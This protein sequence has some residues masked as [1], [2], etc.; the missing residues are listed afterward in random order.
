MSN[1]SDNKNLPQVRP[2]TDIALV[3]K[4]LAT[5]NKALTTI[6][7]EKFIKFLERNKDAARFF[8]DHISLYSNV[9]DMGFIEQYCDQLDWEKLSNNNS[10]SWS[11]EL[12]ERYADKWNWGALGLSVNKSLPWSETLIES[13]KEK[14]DWGVLGLSV[15]KSLPWSELLIKRFKH[16]WDWKTLSGNNSLPWSESLIERFAD[17]WE[18]GGRFGLSHNKSLPWSES[19]IERFADKWE[20]GGNFRSGLPRGHLGRLYLEYRLGL[21]G[22]KFLPWSVSLIERYKDKLDWGRFG[23]SGN[24]SLPWSESLIERYKDKW[25]WDGLSFNESLP[26][27]ES[28]IERYKGVANVAEEKTTHGVTLLDR[29]HRF[30]AIFSGYYGISPTDHNTKPNKIFGYDNLDHRLID[31]VFTEFEKD[32]GID[33]SKDDMALERLKEGLQKAINDISTKSETNINLPFFFCPGDSEPKHLNMK[34]SRSKFESMDKW[35]WKGLS[36][37]KS[38]PWSEALIER[39]ADQWDWEML[40]KNNSLPWSEELIER[41]KDKWKWGMHGLSSNNS[42]PWSESFI[43]RYK[44]KWHWRNYGLSSNQSLPWSESFIERYA[45]KWDWGRLGLSSNKSL[46]WNEAFIQGFAN[47]WGWTLLASNKGVRKVFNS[48]TKQEISTA[49]ERIRLARNRNDD[50]LDNNNACEFP[51]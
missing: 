48:W 24:K 15:N 38:L 9:L 32:H 20:W 23:L 36:C 8:I 25:S 41:Y 27:S 45:D 47:K 10:L 40:S 2:N 49:L 29:N 16:R 3:S 31:W 46:P 44:D 33:F 39:Y 1:D 43:E 34:L 12:I 7:R 18:W 22:N 50:D 35:N 13:Y 17:K 11:E 4:Q 14:W 21:S 6:N 42:L 26:W 30:P 19:F 5:V 37:N 51:F 28:L